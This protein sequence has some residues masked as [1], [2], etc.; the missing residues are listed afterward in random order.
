MLI[1]TFHTKMADFHHKSKFWHIQ[2]ICGKSIRALFDF[3]PIILLQN[4]GWNVSQKG[5]R[6]EKHI[7]WPPPPNVMPANNSTIVCQM[8]G[9]Y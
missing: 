9:W 7:C 2:E 8:D 4:H 3:R 1:S 6:M 5:E